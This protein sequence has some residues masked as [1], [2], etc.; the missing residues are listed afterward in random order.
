ML[1]GAVHGD[2]GMADDVRVR[3]CLKSGISKGWR[4]RPETQRVFCRRAKRFC[5]DESRRGALDADAGVGPANSVVSRAGRGLGVDQP[6][7]DRGELAEECL[8]SVVVVGPFDQVAM[9]MGSSCRPVGWRSFRMSFYRRLKKPSLA[10][11][12]PLT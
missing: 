1:N 4:L 11:H 9:A 12:A 7:L 5:W 8:P 10:H 3:L 2:V 6:E